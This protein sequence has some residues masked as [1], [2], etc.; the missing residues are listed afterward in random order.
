V[1]TLDREFWIRA[2]DE[3][4]AA[5]EEG[6][7]RLCGYD[8]ATGDG[9]H[10]TSMLLGF[11]ETQKSLRG[12][13]VREA[14]EVFSRIGGAFLE[15]VG[16]VTGIAFGSLFEA[17]GQNAEGLPD[18]DAGALHRMFAAGIAA[19]KKR[20]NVAE[21]DKSMIDALSPAVDA[22]RLAAEKG[23]SA[24]TALGHS[25]QAAA[26]GME[27]TIPME[28][29]VGRARYQSGKGKGHV[30]AG[31]ASICLFFQTLSRCA[32]NVGE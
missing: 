12:T 19:V 1:S 14:G 17:A 4:V 11:R 3:L 29:R 28:A 21:G 6:E 15:N 2:V 8:G 31:A 24:A 22:L 25:A 23:E 32:Q 9:D 13:T 16:G 5:F 26:A 7:I 20:G 27:A 30:D 18:I 10:G